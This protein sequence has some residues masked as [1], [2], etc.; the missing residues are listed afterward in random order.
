MGKL[1]DFLSG[2]KVLE[3]VKSPING[4]IEVIRSLAFGTYIQVANLTQSGGILFDVWKKPLKKVAGSKKQVASVLILGLGGGTVVKLV[5]KFWP[6]AK[7]TGV[8]LDP[9][10][11]ELGKKYLGLDEKVVEISISDAFNFLATYDSQHTTKFDLILID[12]YVGDDF[13]KKFES[14]NYIQ[15]TRTILASGGI[16]IFNRLYYGEKRAQSMKFGERLEKIFKKV[17]IVFPEANVMFICKD[18]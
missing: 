11:I 5:K 13:P 10:M 2:T 7:I 17:E 3:K 16:V 12:L 15:R 18:E 14:E 9:I 4:E 8:D 6:E 1:I